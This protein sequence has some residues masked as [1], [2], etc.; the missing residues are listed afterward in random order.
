MSYSSDSSRSMRRQAPNGVPTRCGDRTTSRV[1]RD[2]C[3]SLSTRLVI[4][5]P[6]D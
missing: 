6:R 4:F 3:Y 2:A 5:S 1:E